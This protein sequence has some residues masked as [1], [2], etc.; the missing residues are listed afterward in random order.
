MATPNPTTEVRFHQDF[1]KDVFTTLTVYEI[2]QCDSIRDLC[3]RILGGIGKD[4]ID[5]PVIH[6]FM[7]YHHP[8]CKFYTT[9]SSK[10]MKGV[11]RW[12]EK[13]PTDAENRIDLLLF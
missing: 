1:T 4:Q 2:Y 7:F 9:R 8:V 3:W 6:G 11:M 13:L 10:E 12:L 5:V